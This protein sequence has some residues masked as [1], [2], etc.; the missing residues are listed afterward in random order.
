ML[1]VP[2][3]PSPDETLRS[4]RRRLATGAATGVLLV[5]AMAAAGWGL[6]SL[7]EGLGRIAPPLAAALAAAGV[8]VPLVLWLLHLMRQLDGSRAALARL[9]TLDAATGVAKRPHFLSCAER[10][11]SRARRYGTGAALLV[12]EVDQVARLIEGRGLVAAET[13]LRALAL[14]TEQTLRG[15]DLIARFGDTQLAVWLVHADPTGALDVAERIRERAEQM[16]I[17]CGAHPLRIT[18]SVGVGALRPAHQNLSALVDDTEAALL[19]AQQ[20]GGNCVR[21]APVDPQRRRR[22]DAPPP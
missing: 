14:D 5:V 20:A 22:A 9:D 10:E 18:V 2:T 1:N 12:A 17:P 4:R 6:A 3:I 21:S 16:E 11:W 8:G 7:F 13:V 19:A 15:G